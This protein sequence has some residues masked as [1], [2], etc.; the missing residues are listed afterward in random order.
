MRKNS[1]SCYDL[2][3]G[4]TMPNVELEIYYVIFE[5]HDPTSAHSGIIVFIH[6]G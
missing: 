2:D 1:K 4:Q 6:T 3:L 5:F